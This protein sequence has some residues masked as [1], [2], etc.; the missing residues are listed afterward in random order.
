[1]R[2]VVLT[3]SH[4]AT[5]SV[6]SRDGCAMAMMIAVTTAMRPSVQQRPASLTRTSPALTAIASPLDG[7]AMGT[8]IALIVAMNW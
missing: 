5:G 4:A 3:S 7:G 6:Y 1:M 2:H 8:S